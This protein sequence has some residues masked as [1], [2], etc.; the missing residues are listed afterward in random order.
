MWPLLSI[1]LLMFNV[2]FDVPSISLKPKWFASRLTLFLR[3]F[4]ESSETFNTSELTVALFKTL[5]LLLFV[6]V[7][8][9]KP[10]TFATKPE[11]LA[12]KL[13][14][15]VEFVSTLI[16]ISEV[17]FTVELSTFTSDVWETALFIFVFVSAIPPA[18]LIV[19]AILSS[20]FVPI[21]AVDEISTSFALMFEPFWILTFEFD[22]MSLY[23]L[24]PEFT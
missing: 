12:S 9:E 10:S 24:P 19:Y 22:V 17:A 4:D 8:L 20:F 14:L 7:K 13:W 6:T 11:P 21:F 18:A 23:K 15:K 1:K 5:N 3:L 2:M 16:F